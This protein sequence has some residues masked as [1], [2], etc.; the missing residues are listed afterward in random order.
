[1]NTVFEL[2]HVLLYLG[3]GYSYMRGSAG[4]DTIVISDKSHRQKGKAMGKLEWGAR[5][6]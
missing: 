6:L 5:I 4:R 3:R 1:M 2:K